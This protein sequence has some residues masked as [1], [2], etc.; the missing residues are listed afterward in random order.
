MKT[1]YRLATTVCRTASCPK[2]GTGVAW[3]G[4]VGN[5]TQ[6]VGGQLAPATGDDV[7]VSFTKLPSDL[8]ALSQPLG[9]PVT[10]TAPVRVI[11]RAN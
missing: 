2:L 3:G 10:D 1:T 11:T 6:E 9:A 4:T 7:D 5:I 8:A